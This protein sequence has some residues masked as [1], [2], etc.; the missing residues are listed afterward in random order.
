MS[1][2]QNQNQNNDHDHKTLT[3][4]AQAQ[5]SM[6]QMNM[7]LG[8]APSNSEAKEYLD[9]LLSAHEQELPQTIINTF[10]ILFSRDFPL[11]KLDR[12]QIETMLMQLHIESLKFKCSLPPNES[13]LQGSSRSHCLDDVSSKKALTADMEKALD[14]LEMWS[15]AR[16]YR[17]HKGYERNMQVQSTS[18]Q[19]IEDMRQQNGSV[20]DKILGG[21]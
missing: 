4:K 19:K 10:Q 11:S 16:F 8:M 14:L 13:L 15:R 17:A 5:Q 21:G 12:R 20:L 1:Q 9:S 2:K 7:D 6:K 18:I 3:N